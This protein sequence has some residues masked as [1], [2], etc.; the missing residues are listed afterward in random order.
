MDDVW[1]GRLTGANN[2]WTRTSRARMKFIAGI[3]IEL[4]RK[5][6]RQW[7]ISNGMDTLHCTY[8]NTNQQENT[9]RA[10]ARMEKATVVN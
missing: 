2:V 4:S 9:P 3:R 10:R 7:H 8:Y 6:D 1:V 5:V